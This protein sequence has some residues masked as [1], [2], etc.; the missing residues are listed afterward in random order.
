MQCPWRLRRFQQIRW[1]DNTRL[2][3]CTMVAVQWQ[4]SMLVPLPVGYADL[5]IVFVCAD[6][7]VGIASPAL[8][9]TTDLALKTQWPLHAWH[10]NVH[11][12]CALQLHSACCPWLSRRAP[13]MQKRNGQDSPG[14]TTRLRTI[15]CL[16]GSGGGVVASNF[17]VWF[18]K[19]VQ[20]AIFAFCKASVR[21]VSHS[22]LT[23]S[24]RDR[25][26]D[27]LANN[28]CILAWPNPLPLH[29]SSGLSVSEN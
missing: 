12:H 26:S 13:D 6:P 5:H 29:T 3:F 21:N 23:F 9:Q 24:A 2:R 28:A 22:S 1:F 16:C 11:R 17:C 8:Q 4:R 7:S 10:C 18:W 20:T 25:F 19:F 14:A 27:R 15:F